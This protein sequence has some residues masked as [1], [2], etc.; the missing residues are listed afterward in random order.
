MRCPATSLRIYRARH[1]CIIWLP[2]APH[3]PTSWSIRVCM[4]LNTTGPDGS[5]VHL[6]IPRKELDRNWGKG[7][8]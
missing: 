1:I 8:F 7:W 5:D 2:I 6:G 4:A 3:Q